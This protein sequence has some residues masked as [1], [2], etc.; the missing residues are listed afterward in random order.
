MRRECTYYI[1]NDRKAWE[2]G[3]NVDRYAGLSGPQSR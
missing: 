3:T 2:E 1:Y